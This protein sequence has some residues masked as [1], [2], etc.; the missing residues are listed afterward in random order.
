MARDDRAFAGLQRRLQHGVE[1]GGK[2]V[3]A[4]VR[5]PRR[6][7]AAAVTAVVVRDH[8]IVGGQVGDLVRPHGNRAGDAVGQH[9]RIAVFWT[10]DLDVQAGTVAGADGHGACLRQCV[11]RWECHGFSDR[12]RQRCR[13]QIVP[14][15]RNWPVHPRRLNGAMRAIQIPRLD[16]PR[17]AELVEIEEPVDDG[18]SV[19]DVTRPESHFRTHCNRA[20]SINTRPT[21]HSCRVPSSPA[22]CAAHPAGSR[23]REGRSRPRTDDVHRRD[24]RS[25]CAGTGYCL[26]AAR[27][28][29]RSRQ[30]RAFCSTT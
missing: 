14:S 23:R 10:E 2:E 11:C 4:V 30:A 20:G 18:R 26:Q 28:R 19:V 15:G 12:S 16:G 17:A 9:D 6:Q 29:C 21:S 13:R 1:V 22:S 5:P 8:P 25:R 7:A 3:Q 27:L 24:G